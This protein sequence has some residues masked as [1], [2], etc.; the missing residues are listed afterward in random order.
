[1]NLN[2]SGINAVISPFVWVM[3]SAFCYFTAAGT[4]DAWQGRIYFSLVLVLTA[5]SS[6]M[7]MQ[8]APGPMNERGRIKKDAC[9]KDKALTAAY[10]LADSII[11][12]F[13]AGLEYRNAY[14]YMFGVWNLLLGMTLCYTAFSISVWAMAVNP[15][16]E[17]FTRIQSD[18]KQYVV[19]EGPYGIVRHPGYLSMALKPMVLPLIADSPAALITAL[20]P[21]AICVKRAL[22]ED[23]ILTRGLKGYAQYSEKVRYKLLPWVI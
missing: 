15:F 12:P 2:F 13:V 18:R 14:G 9:G 10:L 20:I 7:M 11:V 17:R 8:M 22:D 16:F 19:K 3:V 21:F 4:T 23:R 1:M 6:L 5:I